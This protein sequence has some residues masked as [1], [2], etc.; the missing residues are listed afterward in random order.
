MKT[1]SLRKEDI[2]RSWWL[3][4][5]DGKTLGRIATGIATKLRGKHKPEYTPHIDTGDYVVVV[6][7]EKVKLTGNK[8]KDKIY[9]R[10]TGY[11][12]GI[13]NIN[14]AKL[15]KKHPERLIEKAVKGMLPRNALG[16]AMYRKLR[17]YAGDEHPHKGQ[18]P[19]GMDI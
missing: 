2:E 1:V 5:A 13:K 3:V 11:P 4:D 14:A 12:G 9:W 7:A 15:R 18:L 8:E 10:H 19:I 6:N 16:R 17:V